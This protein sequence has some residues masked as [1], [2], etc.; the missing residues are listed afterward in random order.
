MVCL[1]ISGLVDNGRYATQLF[2]AAALPTFF[3]G[4]HCLYGTSMIPAGSGLPEMRFSACPCCGH[5]GFRCVW[6]NDRLEAVEDWKTFFYGGCRFIADLHACDR[7]GYTFIN[8][9]TPD[10]KK[11]YATQDMET[12]VALSTYRDRYFHKVKSLVFPKSLGAP[13]TMLDVGCGDG[14]WLSVWPECPHR[15]G[16]EYSPDFKSILL[17]RKISVLDE[18]GIRERTFDLITLFD[19]LEHVENPHEFLASIW[20]CVSEGGTLL[21][22]VPAMDK[23]I[24]R[25]LGHRYYLYCPMHFSY[26]GKKCLRALL[27]SVC[28]GGSYNL[29]RAPAMGA[30]VSAVFKW[31]G[32][33]HSIPESMNFSLPVG[34]SANVIAVVS[35]NGRI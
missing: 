1:L 8:R 5:A 35:K 19:V 33:K 32:V 6:N 10:W 28:S 15:Y 17:D 25:L 11:F 21:I 16:S 27:D 9:L 29:V 20:S 2:F 30:D 12:Y 13:D 24:S 26:F 22:S 23:W 4:R 14:G 7:C 31:L 3:H 18:Q 34:Y